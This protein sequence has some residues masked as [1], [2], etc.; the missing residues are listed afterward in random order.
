MPWVVA[1]IK[2]LMAA[3]NDLVI[4]DVPIE[5][6]GL[7]ADDDIV[8]DSGAT[9]HRRPGVEHDVIPNFLKT[10]IFIATD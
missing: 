8:A 2:V 4:G 7:G 10:T 1:D 6:H 9:D 5:H 3:Q